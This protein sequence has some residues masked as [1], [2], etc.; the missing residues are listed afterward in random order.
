MNEIKRES[1]VCLFT[2][3]Y[4]SILC[5]YR[6]DYQ[7]SLRCRGDQCLWPVNRMLES[8]IDKVVNGRKRV[9][10]FFPL[11]GKAVDMK[12]W[13]VNQRTN[14]RRF[15]SYEWLKQSFYHPPLFSPPGWPIWVIQWLEWTW[16]RR[17]LSSSLKSR[18]W[19]S[20]KKRSQLSLVQ[21]FTRYHQDGWRC[22]FSS[23]CI[24]CGF[25]RLTAWQCPQDTTATVLK[26]W[27]VGIAHW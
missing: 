6:A 7:C 17:L 20:V 21:R 16:L 22:C 5:Q 2:Y 19:A 27:V 26:G 1:G 18:V 12:W 11:C 25:H 24:Y 15:L 9:R 10:F 14:Q 23:D 3:V 4:I 8:H 13:V